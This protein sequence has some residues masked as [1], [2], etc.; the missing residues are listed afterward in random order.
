MRARRVEGTNRIILSERE[1][2]AEPYTIC[3][4]DSAAHNWWHI[5][6]QLINDGGEEFI[7]NRSVTCLSEMKFSPRRSVYLLY[8][9]EVEILK[10]HSLIQWVEKSSMFNRIKL[11]Q[12][13][14]DELFDRH[15]DTNRFKQDISNK[16]LSVNPGSELNFTQWGIYR[17][18]SKEN[19]FV[20]LGTTTTNSDVQ[21]SLTGKNVDIVVMDTGVRW[22]HPEFLNRQYTSVPEGMSVKD[23]TRVRDILIHGQNDYGINWESYGLVSP[24]SGSLSNYTVSNVLE[25]STFNGSWH[26]SHVAGTSAGNQFGVAFDANIW[27]IACVDRSDVGFSDP[28]DGFDYIRVWHKNKP[29]NPETGR[30]NP[31]IVNCSW[32]L[33]QFA[34]WSDIEN[35]PYTVNF[36]GNI[37]NASD[38]EASPSFLP[39]VYYIDTQGVYYEFTSTMVGSQA[40]ADELFDDLDCKD[41]IV[42]CSAGNSGSGNGKQDVEGGEDYENRF[43]TGLM[44]YGGVIPQTADEDRSEHFNRLGTPAITHQ[45]QDD[46][47]IVVGALDS[48]VSTSG[49]TSER[50]AYYSNNGPSIDVW[51]AGSTILSPYNTGYQDPRNSSFYNNYLNGTSMASPNVTGVIALHL[52]SKPS[53]TRVDIRNWIT[54]QASVDIHDGFLDAYR[55]NDPVGAGTSVQYWSDVY[56]LRGSSKKVLFNP[57]AN[58]DLP[59]VSGISLDQISFTQS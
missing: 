4:T 31:T 46:A 54:R 50:K 8:E 1:R 18:Q 49:I 32:G 9:S 30:K 19:N 11:E 23:V 44:Y 14:N 58:N 26:G 33:R 36:R 15:V 25:S 12:R 16:R 43:V 10:N 22:D 5:H 57:Y 27:T 39:A 6:H 56:G 47:P 28:S 55:N 35:Y 13:K 7:P 20:G 59:L 37:Y 34:Y 42:V 52:E 53:S 24:G 29:I 17:H 41:I 3:V 2:I 45:G 21:Y 51:S 48:T 38:I 40:T